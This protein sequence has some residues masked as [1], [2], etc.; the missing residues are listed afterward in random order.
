MKKMI[1]CYNFIHH[2]K[3]HSFMSSIILILIVPVKT[4][5]DNNKKNF[6]LSLS[7][8]LSGAEES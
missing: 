3:M 4:L 6:S 5:T 7:L 8:S 1:I 2:D